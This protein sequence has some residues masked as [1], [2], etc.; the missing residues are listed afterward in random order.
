MFD[1]ETLAKVRWNH[2]ADQFNQWTELDAEEKEKLIAA[3]GNIAVGRV[4]AVVNSANT[5]RALKPDPFRKEPAWLVEFSD[6]RSPP[7]YISS[8]AFGEQLIGV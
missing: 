7:F 1:P 8:K 6:F 2:N 3:E 5:V 4:Y